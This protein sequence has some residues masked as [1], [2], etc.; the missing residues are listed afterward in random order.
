MVKG[1]HLYFRFSPPLFHNFKWFNIKAATVHHPAIH[2]EVHEL[3]AKG[4]IEPLTG[5]AGFA[6][7]CILVPKHTGGL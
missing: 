5:I 3:L 2:K 4:S 1:Q 7:K 6:F